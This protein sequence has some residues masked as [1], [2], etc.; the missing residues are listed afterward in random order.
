MARARIKNRA[1]R[2]VH[3]VQRVRGIAEFDTVGRF[4][5]L[6]WL[7]R[8]HKARLNESGVVPERAVFS[9]SWSAYWC[10]ST[11]SRMFSPHLQHVVGRKDAFA[12]QMV[13][14]AQPEC[15]ECVG[16]TCAVCIRAADEL[17]PTV[18]GRGD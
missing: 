2:G 17:E 9:W 5:F 15:D 1:L 3:A 11:C 8:A 10:T 7:H 12:V 14:D 4:F 16:L 6:H 13:V 18:Q